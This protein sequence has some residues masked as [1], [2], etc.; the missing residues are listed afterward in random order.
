MH[1]FGIPSEQYQSLA[2]KVDVIFHC[3]AQVNTMAAYTTLRTS[4]VQ[5]TIEVI[6]FA[7]H[8]L[9]KPIY[10]ISTLSAAYKKNAAGEFIEQFPDTDSSQL[11][12][13]YALSKW[14]SERLLTQ[15][16]NRGLP[17]HIYRAGYILGQSD[18]GITNTND[19]LLLLLKGCIQLGY[20]PLWEEKIAI[21]PVDFVSKAIVAMSLY[22][23]RES[24]VLHLDHPQ[25]IWWKDLINF[26]CQYGFS[27]Q[28]CEHRDWLNRLTQVNN[29]NALY[30]FLPVYLSQATAPQTPGTNLENSEQLLRRLKLPWPVV[31]EKL[32][33]KYFDYLCDI[34]FFP[35]FHK[36]QVL[37]KK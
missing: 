26:A 34:G 7:V 33:K 6:N 36:K 32:L 37:L 1:Q 10:Y 29:E 25:G 19:A 2:E 13:G 4:N 17:I 23:P 18:T 24:A 35:V 11:V 21:L 14:V 15:V 16:K 31:D 27:I 8:K 28:F 30:P 3:G 22:Q 20:A 9:D 12:G 5:G